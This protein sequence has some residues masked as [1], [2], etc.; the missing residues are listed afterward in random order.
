MLALANLQSFRLILKTN[1][2][3]LVKH[4]MHIKVVLCSSVA[5]KKQ[6]VNRYWSLGF[7]FSLR[8][9]GQIGFRK[10]G[11]CEFVC[12][13][14]NFEVIFANA[15]GQFLRLYSKTSRTFIK[16]FFVILTKMVKFLAVIY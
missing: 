1:I 3:S 6:T 9:L 15:R 10:V 13:S 4:N 11:F 16:F 7:T 5:V 2:F 8:L 14:K 12:Y